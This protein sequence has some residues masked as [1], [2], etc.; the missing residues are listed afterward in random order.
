MDSVQN[1]ISRWGYLAVFLGTL[2]EGEITMVVSG[3]LASQNIMDIRLVLLVGSAG[4]FLGDQLFFIAGRI[5]NRFHALTRLNRNISYRKAR[6]IVRR[7]GSYIVLVSRYLVGMRMALSF[8]LGVMR[9]PF[10]QFTLLNLISAAVWAPTVG[11]FGYALG[12]VAV[13][14]LGRM[15]HYEKILILSTLLVVAVAFAFKRL[16]KRVEEERLP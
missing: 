2:L 12:T 4:G 10:R 8:A 5:S 9:M 7:Y 15:K 14:A 16:V 1:I 6:R 3:F 11:F 13:K